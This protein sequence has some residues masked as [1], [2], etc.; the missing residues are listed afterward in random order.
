[1][2]LGIR[3]HDIKKAPLEERLSIAHEQGFACGHLAL[4]KVISEYPV[5]D[6]ALTPGYALYLKKLFAKNE[7]DIAVLGCYLNLA[8]PNL[9]SLNK[10]RKR[11]LTHI[12]FAS[13]LDV[14]VV[15]TET[16]AV[17]RN[18]SLKRE[19]TARKHWTFSFTMS[20]RW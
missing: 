14:G 1:M 5:D 11:Y 13:L 16:G 4:S 17:T 6:G 10:I 7:L 3:L 18:T 20:V 12:R 2:Q 19:I 9:E 8:N 15:G